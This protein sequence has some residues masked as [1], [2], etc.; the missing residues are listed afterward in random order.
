MIAVHSICMR[1]LHHSQAH[2]INL[3]WFTT[4]FESLFIIWCYFSKMQIDFG[5]V[6]CVSLV[7]QICCFERLEVCLNVFWNRAVSHFVLC[8]VQKTLLASEICTRLSSIKVSRNVNPFQGKRPCL[9]LLLLTCNCHLSC[10]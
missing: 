9:F 6:I 1:F 8:Y 4:T 10:G 3:V 7:S 2:P 5:Q